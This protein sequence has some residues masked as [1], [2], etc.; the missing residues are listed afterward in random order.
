[1]NPVRRRRLW[2]AVIVICAALIAGERFLDSRYVL[3]VLMYHNVDHR[4]METKLSVSPESFGRQME[5]LDRAGYSVVSLHDA[6]VMIREGDRDKRTVALTFDD[7]PSNF[8]SDAFPVLK[9]HG[10]TATVFMISDRVGAAG[11]LSAEQVKEISDAGLDI[12]SHSVSHADLKELNAEELKREVEGS[13]A[14]LEEVTGREPAFF[15]YPEGKFNALV[16]KAVIDAGYEGA[17]ATNPGRGTPYDDVYAI[18]RTRISRTSDSMVV[19]EIE[20]SGYYSF[21]KEQRDD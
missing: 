1:M 6:A 8:Y 7:G 9:K 10:F 12:G 21:I 5:Y 11:Y 20:T 18:R 16:R 3:P 2:A 19:F 14:V 17:V 4:H 15:A 13:R